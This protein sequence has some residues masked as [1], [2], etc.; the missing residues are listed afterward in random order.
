MSRIASGDVITVRP[1][2]NI[3]TALAAVGTVIVLTGLV[4]FFLKVSEVLGPNA[5]LFS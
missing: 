2:N 3:Y 1:T 4:L 5:S